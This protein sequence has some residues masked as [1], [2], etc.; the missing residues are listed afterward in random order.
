MNVEVIV[1]NGGSSSGKSSIAT[2]LQQQLE[3]TWLTLGVDDLIRALSHGPKDTTGGG[4]LRFSSDGS[5]SVGE[6]FHQ[7]EAAWYQGIGA[8]ARAGGAV[9]ADE[10]FLEGGRSQGR[11]EAA[12]HGL[13][14]V[15]VGVHCDP[16]VAVTRE[17]QRGDRIRGQARD[18]AVRVHKGV[19]YDLVVDTTKTSPSQCAGTIVEWL[20]RADSQLP[21]P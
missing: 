16:D 7:A 19:R 17:V 6:A 1:L 18:Q 15:W 3:G 10:V 20:T 9:I 11:L 5:I 14:V 8:I 13:S 21:S 2:S 12:L 4:S